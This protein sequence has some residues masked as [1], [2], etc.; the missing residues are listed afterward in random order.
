MGKSLHISIRAQ[1]MA[2]QYIF[3]VGVGIIGFI[4]VIFLTK[5]IGLAR[6]LG[7]FQHFQV[8]FLLMCYL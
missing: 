5:S 7:L 3:H 1:V 2:L 6:R 4:T 8:A